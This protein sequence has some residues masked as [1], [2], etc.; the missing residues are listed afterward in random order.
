LVD[1]CIHF[2]FVY[3]LSLRRSNNR[4]RMSTACEK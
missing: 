2:L 4:E 3:S 1:I